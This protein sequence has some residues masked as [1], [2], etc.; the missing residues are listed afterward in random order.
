MGKYDFDTYI[1]RRGTSSMKWDLMGERFGDPDL[2]PYWVA[3]MDFKS[4]PEVISAIEDKLRHG[5]LGYP[6]VKESLVES[7]LNW[8]KT[9]HGWDIDRSAVSWAPGVVGGLAFAIEAYTK[10][11]DGIMI[12]TPVYP[13]FYEIIG[14]SGRHIVRNPLKRAG[15]RFVM[16]IEGLEKLVTPTCRTLILCSPHNPVSRVWTKAELEKLAELAERRDMLILADEI[17]QDIVYSDA[18]HTCFASLPNMGKRTV[19]FIAPSKTFNLAGLSSS[20]AIIP[21]HCLME[22]YKS[23]LVRFHLSRLNAI[24]LAAME[25]AYSKCADWADE[26]VAY[27]EGNRDY[28]E[29]FIKERMPKAKL[30]HPEGTYIFWIDFRGY[31]FD[32]KALKEFL[33]REAR[34]AL[35]DGMDF[36]EEGSGFARLNVGTTRKQLTE[37]LEMIA[38]A[39]ARKEA[40]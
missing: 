18:I 28:A 38:A 37:G 13:P 35:N 40:C 24:G 19:T 30:D 29:K 8:E 27:L 33:V 11:G 9:R 20:V 21:D 6:V 5:V 2:L 39:L 31:G 22:Q 25:A 10:P 12:Q 32:A 17:H 23:V 26:M 1:E 34:V 16:D 36:G 3:D 14:T 15:G 4:P 7:V